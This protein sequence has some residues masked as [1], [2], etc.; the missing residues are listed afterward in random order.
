MVA[1]EYTEAE[2]RIVILA[3]CLSGFIAPLLS[4]MMNL[5]LVSIGNEFSVGSHQLAYV[6]TAFLLSSVVFMVPMSKAADI[7][8]KKRVFLA[9]LVMILAASVAAMFSPSF[10]WLIACRVVMGAGAASLSSTSISLITDVFPGNRRG[11]AIGFQTMCVYIGLAAG[12]PVGGAMNDLFGWHSL[13]LLIVPLAVLSF[14]AM[15][16]FRHEISP[17]AGTRFDASGS[18]LYGLGIV[19]AMGGVINMPQTWA[20]ASLAA[21]VVLLGLFA[22]RQ[23]RIPHF[24]L[25]VRLF[26]NRVF[27]GSCVAAFLNYAASYSISYFMALYLQSIGALTA[28]EAGMLMLT[29]AAIQAFLTPFFGRKSDRLADK[30]ILPTVG[31][32]LTGLGVA[33]FLLYGTELQL[34]LVLATMA[35]VGLGVSMFSAPNT[36]V[37]MGSVPRE[38]TSEASAMVSVMRQTGMMVS[39][40]VAMLFI[41]VIMGGA[42]NLVPENY[43]VF[44]DVMHISFGVCL[45]MCVVGMVA[46]LLRG[47]GRGM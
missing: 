40:G 17:D 28:T 31:M 34:P 18:V 14:I 11:G 29:Q 1:G 20:F 8:G 24:L 23:L 5:S 35:T 22:R 13:F 10:G 47:S 39:M 36:S 4:T 21:G 42:D 9:G 44:V 26:R 30:R 27:T 41:S 43:G 7:F 33:T 6:N 16:M 32:G 12:P 19:L 25:N 38:E 45:V 2:R 46:S 37:I 15:T 3:C